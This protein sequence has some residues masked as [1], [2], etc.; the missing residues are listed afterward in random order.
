MTKINVT[1]EK[2]KS[3]MACSICKQ[4]CGVVKNQL[5]GRKGFTS[6]SHISMCCRAKLIIVKEP[7][8]KS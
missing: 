2:G 1:I 8:A 3:Y 4:R 6:D 7:S 5:R